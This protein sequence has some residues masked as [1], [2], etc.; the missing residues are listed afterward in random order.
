MLFLPKR[1]ALFL[2]PD[3]SV[4][5]PILLQ[6]VLIVSKMALAASFLRTTRKEHVQGFLV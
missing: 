4:G 1:R 3:N 2:M 5:C 6:L